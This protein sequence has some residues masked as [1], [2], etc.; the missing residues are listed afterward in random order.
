MADIYAN[1]NTSILAVNNHFFYD[2]ED[3]LSFMPEEI[4]EVR[5]NGTDGE[6]RYDDGRLEPITELENE[7]TYIS[8]FNTL[9]DAELAAKPVPPPSGAAWKPQEEVPTMELV[10][11]EAFLAQWQRDNPTNPIVQPPPTPTPAPELTFEQIAE[12]FRSR[13]NKLLQSSD[14][15]QLSNSPLTDA[16]K[17]EWES[18]RVLLRDAPVGIS[19]THWESMADKND[20]DWENNPNWPTKPS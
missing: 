13:R 20:E 17:A 12:N 19:T 14:W 15:T 4:H 8:V 9:R 6:I 11:V 7:E 2:L 3:E 16:K 10:D 18:Y 5:W 1:Q